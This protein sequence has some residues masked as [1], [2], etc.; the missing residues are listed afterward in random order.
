L[1][2]R[3]RV[4]VCNSNVS[5]EQHAGLGY[6]RDRLVMIPNGFDLERFRPDPAAG[7]AVRAELDVPADASLVGMVARRHP[8]KGHADFLRMAARVHADRPGTVFLMAGRGLDRADAELDA[9]VAAGGLE[10]A[11]RRVGSR[12]DVASVMAALD[13]FVMAST[14]G[15]GF[16]NV[17][18][19]AM[20]CGVPCVTT[21]VGD[22]AVVVD[23]LGA[24]VPRGRPAELARG[25]GAILD[26]DPAAR[27]D[28]GSRCRESVGKRF[29]L[30]TIARRYEDLYS[31]ES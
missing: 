29:A 15:E 27:K 28:R 9:L 31:P 23:A 12:A 3:P 25:V 8:M 20:A 14:F 21:D 24:V 4:I 7:R 30:E 13:V 16:P 10:G 11:V 6:L 2:N 26:L 1:S 22:A 19:E 17:L 5:L 18:G